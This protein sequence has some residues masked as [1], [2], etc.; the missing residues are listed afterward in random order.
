MPKTLPRFPCG[1]DR[2]PG[3]CP[4][5]VLSGVDSPRLLRPSLQ[6]L[7]AGSEFLRLGETASEIFV[8]VN[9][10][11]LLYALLRDGRR[12]VLKFALAGDILGLG[13]VTAVLP[14]TAQALTDLSVC[15]IARDRLMDAC[16]IH[17]GLA[18]T[19]LDA[20]SRDCGLAYEHL[21]SV[22]RCTARER[23]ARLL[24][25]II[26]RARD[27]QPDLEAS[28]I[29][30][31]LTQTQIGDALG[32]TAVHVNRMLG[33]LRDEGIIALSRRTLCVLDETGLAA[34]AGAEG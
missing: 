22:G 2:L 26:R 20:M 32:L 1:D 33:A 23:L 9:G 19:L 24:L 16:R 12:Q 34:A 14:Y 8:V 25:E 10:W 30:L 27:G 6:H 4:C 5:H 15:V 13:N 31:P 17:P 28:A 21:T 3:R 29:P 18:L 7:E 11:A